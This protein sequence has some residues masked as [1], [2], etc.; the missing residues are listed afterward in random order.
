MCPCGW[1][2][3]FASGEDHRPGLISGAALGHDLDKFGYKPERCPTTV[4]A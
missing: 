1:P 2:G 4:T 3:A